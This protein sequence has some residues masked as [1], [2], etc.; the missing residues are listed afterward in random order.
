MDKY[1]DKCNSNI[2]WFE[3][4]RPTCMND[5]IL[6]Q[7]N[8]LLLN[9]LLE[10][11]NIPYN[12]LFYGTPGTGKTTTIHNFINKYQIKHYGKL[13]KDNILSLNASDEC[14]IDVIRHKIKTFVNTNFMFNIGAKFVILDEIDY[15]NFDSQ[16]ALERII[17]SYQIKN[18]KK[19]N[20]VFCLACNYLHK[21]YSLL[22]DNSLL[23]EYYSLNK[24]TIIS[25]VNNILNKEN[26]DITQNINQKIN[27]V[28][29][30]CYPD[31]RLIINEIQKNIY[32]KFSYINCVEDFELLL[33][34][35][36]Y[37]IL[38][39]VK[40]N[41]KTD[42]FFKFS[43]TNDFNDIFELIDRN[44][45]TIQSFISFDDIRTLMFDIIIAYLKFYKQITIENINI[46]TEKM[47]NSINK[48]KIL[49]YDF[50]QVIFLLE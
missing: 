25:L 24:E 6:T 9:S 37:Y 36:L 49:I 33:Y 10:E 50:L 41:T 4:Y 14:N 18:N 43:N 27:N 39:D 3:K 11:K 16:V 46:I 48:S 2:P 35:I 7:K 22:I 28:I 23:F 26:I 5:I 8:K 42:T 30:K 1:N 47:N 44:I 29:D 32:T 45:D 15:M 12:L 31:V 13:Q 34:D 38:Y 21:L 19:H 20:V 17:S 40:Q